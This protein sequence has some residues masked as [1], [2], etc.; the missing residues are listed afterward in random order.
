MKRFNLI[1]I[2]LGLIF[3]VINNLLVLTSIFERSWF[4][5][6]DNLKVFLCFFVAI[7]FYLFPHA[8]SWFGKESD[9][10]KANEIMS[11]IMAFI[12]S[13]GALF[14]FISRPIQH[15]IEFHYNS[16]LLDRITL[17]F[18]IYT[19]ILLVSAIFVINQNFLITISNRLKRTEHRNLS[20]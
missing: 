9:N 16:F 17:R 15:Y 4:N 19:L 3:F 10:S 11:N 18:A 6:W 2:I 8:V 13:Q 7:W 1:S 14:L 5:I 12:L 20:K